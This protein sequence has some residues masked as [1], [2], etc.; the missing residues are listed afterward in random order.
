MATHL[1]CRISLPRS[2]RP[3]DILAFHRRDT[4][5]VSERVDD[6]SL[7][8]GLLWQGVPACLSLRFEPGQ[9]VADL[10]LDGMAPT[11][12]KALLK[13]TVNRMLGLAQDVDAFE[14]RYSNHPLLGQLISK[15]AGLRVPVAVTPFEALSW[16][17]TGQQISVG[18]A[19]SIRRRLIQAT[20]L[21][22]SSGLLCHPGPEEIAGLAPD[23]LRQ[24]GFS[25]SKTRSLQEISSLLIS[26]QL[27]LVEDLQADS[28]EE[29]R[30]R[31]LAVR[32]IGPWT[33][34]YTLLRGF[35]WLDGSLHGDV[36]VRHGIETLL[37]TPE[38]LTEKQAQAWLQAFSPWRALLAAHL[39]A[40]RSNTAY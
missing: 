23:T 25:A 31:L 15:Q 37:G 2:Y 9:A 19:V 22:H 36:A 24:A 38:K 17:I 1:R 40:S 35:G 6:S 32:G 18:A 8:K 39:W 28:I 33:V 14:Q 27:V 11:G 29:L 10:A 4:Q 34:N 16:A 20:Q 5:E 13:A 30:E 26:K 3:Q 12:S 21:R 7:H